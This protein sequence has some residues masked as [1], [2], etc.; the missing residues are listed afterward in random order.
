MHV[1]IL[2]RII[3]IF[4]I[5]DVDFSFVKVHSE[6]ESRAYFW[7]VE[8]NFLFYFGSVGFFEVSLISDNFE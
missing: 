8:N 2:K 7:C 4:I 3:F 6:I 5:S 1:T